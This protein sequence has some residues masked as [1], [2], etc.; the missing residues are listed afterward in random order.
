MRNALITAL[1]CLVLASPLQAESYPYG[2]SHWVGTWRS[3]APSRPA[4]LPPTGWRYISLEGADIRLIPPTTP[5]E[6]R[7]DW[8]DYSVTLRFRVIDSAGTGPLQTMTRRGAMESRT[9]VLTVSYYVEPTIR[10]ARC[11]FLLTARPSP[12]KGSAYRLEAFPRGATICNGVFD[13]LTT[14][15]GTLVPA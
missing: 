8:V 9:G 14:S 2:P 13:F 5:A 11:G 3:W 7:A 4:A 6:I 10:A 12:P 15:T 1:L